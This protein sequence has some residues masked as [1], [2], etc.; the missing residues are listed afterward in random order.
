MEFSESS[1][2]GI[3]GIVAAGGFFFL[4][5][6]YGK[7]ISREQNELVVKALNMD[8]ILDGRDQKDAKL[9]FEDNTV[10]GQFTE[11]FQVSGQVVIY[12][13]QNKRKLTSKGPQELT[14]EE[15]IKIGKNPPYWKAPCYQN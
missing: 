4:G 6:I 1:V 14:D 12:D 9:I 15:L 2:I 13:L 3:I 8:R 10:K 5:I 7:K 11:S